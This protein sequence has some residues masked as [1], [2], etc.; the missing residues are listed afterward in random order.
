MEPHQWGISFGEHIDAE[1]TSEKASWSPIAFKLASK[2]RRRQTRRGSCSEP[3]LGLKFICHEGQRSN[4]NRGDF[5]EAGN[6][7]RR[8]G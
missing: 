2:Y 6:Q 5:G 8:G 1:N 7:V 3:Q 4:G